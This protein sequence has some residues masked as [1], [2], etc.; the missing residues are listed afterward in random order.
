M[1][2]TTIILEKSTRES[3]VR[4][5]RKNQTYDGIINELIS[6]KENKNENVIGKGNFP[7]TG[8]NHISKSEVSK[9]G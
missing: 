7:T 5:G 2:K 6:L 8:T 9:Y 3:L 4:I 1:S